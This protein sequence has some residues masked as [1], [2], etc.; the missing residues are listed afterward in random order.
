M[1]GGQGSLRTPVWLALGLGM[2]SGVLVGSGG[3]SLAALI[4]GVAMGAGIVLAR[5]ADVVGISA[6][7]CASVVALAS[8]GAND[9][10]L[11]TFASAVGYGAAVAV[12]VGGAAVILSRGRRWSA[13]ALGA[14]FLLL[15]AGT[16]GGRTLPAPRLAVSGTSDGE[17][18]AAGMTPRTLAAIDRF[19]RAELR[20]NHLPGVAFSV[21]ANG[22]LVLE[23]GYGVAGSDRRP[24]TPDTPQIVAS[25]SKS[26]TA[27]AV[28]T[29]VE[30]G[31]I[32]FDAPVR[33]Y[34]PWFRVAD[35]TASETITVRQLLNQ[36]SGLD[37]TSAW[38]ALARTSGRSLEDEVRAL[39]DVKLAFPPGHGYA[40]SNRNYQTAGLVVQ[41]VSGEPFGR[42]LEE[43]V[44]GP[45]RMTSSFAA[46]FS[47]GPV[48]AASG[49]RGWFGVPVAM[50]QPF[51]VPATPSG[52]VYSTAHDLGLYLLSHL[53]R[54]DLASVSASMYATLH[55][56]V[57]GYAM[58]WGNVGSGANTELIH[59]G[60]APGATSM[61]VIRPAAG[62]G[63]AVIANHQELATITASD[64]GRGLAT[65]MAAG[66]A[67]AVHTRTGQHLL[68]ALA[69][70]VVLTL[71]MRALS[72]LDRWRTRRGRWGTGLRLGWLVVSG[73]AVP[74]VVF[75]AL[76]SRAS[77]N[78]GWRVALVYA[79]D[80]V[81]VVLVA[82]V[83]AF[84]VALVRAGV[85]V[86]SVR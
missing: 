79:P 14:T 70:V 60:H 6:F 45:A 77:T 22:R 83:A 81:V 50:H 34:L 66:P 52:S 49:Y 26:M 19:V 44:L 35:P 73:L 7:I 40:Y 85:W 3:D 11:A 75:L 31:K 69:L 39:R 42:Y 23:R 9:G 33:T 38:G 1:P 4:V 72:T 67:P 62:W 18:F 37:S 86:A 80:L 21:V 78:G 61:L 25:L 55:R 71:L 58:G 36:S 13:L 59:M 74:G 46:H 63:V 16:I 5:R 47:P 51:S 56:P 12:V 2:A 48:P 82:A 41:V 76:N 29:L 68:V 20:R 15:A 65:I 27:V 57:R 10:S 30:Q 24:M 43:H 64:L 53:G 28:A 84:A 17:A 54:P 8:S 32:R